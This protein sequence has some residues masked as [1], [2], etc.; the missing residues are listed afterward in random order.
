MY[1]VIKTGGKQYK[2]C[3]G[4]VLKVE[5]LIGNP[6]DEV[7]FQDV[8][9]VCDEDNNTKIGFPLV[10]EARVE[11]TIKRQT[12]G[13]KIVVFKSKRRKGYKKKAGHRQLLT[14][15]RINNIVS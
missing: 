1:A 2:V 15:V 4:E 7:S 3:P 6:G 12:K 13:D 11:G 5:K 8:L 14:E 9:M 10:A